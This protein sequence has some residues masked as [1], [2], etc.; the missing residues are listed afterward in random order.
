MRDRKNGFQTKQKKN[1]MNWNEKETEKNWNENLIRVFICI[2]YMCVQVKMKL[3]LTPS[4]IQSTGDG[5]KIMNAIYLSKKNE[6]KQPNEQATQWILEMAIMF[7]S[8]S[9]YITCFFFLFQNENGTHTCLHSWM[10]SINTFWMTE[11]N[12][13][14]F[15]NVV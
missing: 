9:K 2:F 1:K 13:M 14:D 12:W 4:N 11:W 6:A 7:G 8:M 15:V 5:N 10:N 3:S